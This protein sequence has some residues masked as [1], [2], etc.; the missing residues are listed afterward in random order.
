MPR[1][2][3]LGR[4][5]LLAG[6]ALLFVSLFLSWYDPDLTAWEVFEALDLVLAA[7]AVAGIAAA[8]RPDLTP[9]WAAAA[10]PAAALLIVF[11]QMV[12]QPPAAPDA[13]LASGIWIALAG[14]LLMAAGAALSLAAIS[15]TVQV[16]ERD[17]RRRVS[18]VDRRHAAD[19]DLAEDLDADADEAP[20][21]RRST[22]LFGGLGRRGDEAVAEP[23]AAESGIAPAAGSSHG[24]VAASGAGSVPGAGDADAGDLERTQP[25][26]ALPDA[27]EEDPRRP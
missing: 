14:T 9:P 5:V 22:S 7:L 1:R 21:D 12:N 23:G 19:D 24:A 8:L 27:D 18:A 16:R 3:D 20:R 17:G 25:M 6:S 13:D 10:V 15:V 11:V 2:I 26:T 4:A